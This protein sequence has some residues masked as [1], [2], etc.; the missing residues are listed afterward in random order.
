MIGVIDSN[1]NPNGIDYP[2][3]GNDDALRAIQLYCDL[4]AGAVFAGLQ[5][6]VTESGGDLGEAE[7]AP[8]EDLSIKSAAAEINS[9][10]TPNTEVLDSI[11][12]EKL[13]PILKPGTEESEQELK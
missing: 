11:P 7:K 13:V 10:D 5:N 3:P 1:S 8:D 4:V 6:E 12:E 9:E 2:I